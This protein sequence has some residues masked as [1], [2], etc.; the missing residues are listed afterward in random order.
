MTGRHGLAG[1]LA[2]AALA[3][4]AAACGKIETW[5]GDP[6]PVAFS[7]Y[8]QRSTKAHASYVA[9]GANFAAGAEIGVFGFYHDG[10]GAT[11]GSWAAD[12]AAGNNIPD[13]MYNQ[14]VTKQDDGSWLY[15]PIKY[16]PNETRTDGNGATSQHIDKL[17]FWGYYPRNAAGLNL[18]AAGTTTAYSN[19]T[20][21][22]PKITFT[23]SEDP[24]E[25]IDLMFTALQKDL[26]KNDASQHGYITNGAVN[27]VF[28]HALALV[29]F[30]LAEGT[31]AKLNTL[32]LTNIKK[33]GTVEDPGT[34]PFVW[35]G[36]DASSE[37]T[38]HI[39]DLDVHEATLLRLLAV[40]QTLNANATFTLNYDIT[41][42]SSDPT[43]PDP[44]VYK[45]DSFSVKLFDNTNADPSKRYGVT[46]WEAGKHYIYKISAG[47][48][49]IEFEEIVDSPDDWSIGNNNI[50]VP[51]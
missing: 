1:R 4:L 34:V 41:F 50:S 27:L 13:Y 46:K 10:N 45:G 51:E 17:S 44:I 8:A 40:P 23:Q 14:L 2:L 39:E 29:E 12:K 9:P 28:K 7:T 25:M 21:G 43:H 6:V 24:D 16:W 31:G 33:S 22:L 15:S 49:R 32:D 47:L 18:Y 20:S 19:E 37:Y 30:Q 26:Y 35:S 42:E 3:L 11:D 5:E 48:D 38:T 36:V